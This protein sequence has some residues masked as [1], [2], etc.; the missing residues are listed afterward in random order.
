MPIAL[1]MSQG[2]GAAPRTPRLTCPGQVTFSW[3]ET[4]HYKPY[5]ASYQPDKVSKDETYGEWDNLYRTKNEKDETVHCEYRNK[6]LNRNYTI[7]RY[8]HK[9]VATKTKFYCI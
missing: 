3:I 2:V 5:P 1:V 8:M 7:P 4:G 6:K 9:C